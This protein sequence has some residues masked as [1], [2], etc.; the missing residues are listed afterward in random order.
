MLFKSLSQQRIIRE[1]LRQEGCPSFYHRYANDILREI[2]VKS[3]ADYGS[4]LTPLPG[5]GNKHPQEIIARTNKALLRK[6]VINAL[7]TR[8][9]SEN[10][11]YIHLAY[12]PKGYRTVATFRIDCDE[13][14]QEDFDRVVNIAE[15]HNIPLTLFI[16]VKSQQSYLPHISAIKERGHDVQLHCHEHQTYDDYQ[17][18]MKNIVKGKYLMEEA[19]INVSGFVAPYGKWN[20]SLNRVME[21][22]RFTFSSEFAID[23]DDLPFFPVFG[24]RV[25]RV[26]QIPVHPVCIGLLWR[27]KFTHREMLNYF[28]NIINEK[29]A[30]CEP[31]MLYGH[32]YREIDKLPKV[33][34]FI[35][36]KLKMLPDIW[37]TTY[38]D[39]AA[40]WR[41]RLN[42]SF[43]VRIDNDLLQIRAK[44]PDPS[45][46]LHIE[47]PDSVEMY[48]PLGNHNISLKK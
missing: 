36:S 46:Q 34:N 23:Y 30:Q 17:K 43:S 16:H 48:L 26:L 38:S 19:G 9:F 40:W 12:Y 3:F 42:T 2:P 39:F 11:P 10:L 8:L 6:A 32:P 7:K 4:K 20:P 45:L 1:I 44:I 41:K 47:L 5:I 21:K 13:S 37:I 15:L 28:E 35:L 31:I 22:L 14:N 33:Y 27:S 29:Y 24:K 25:S 18:N